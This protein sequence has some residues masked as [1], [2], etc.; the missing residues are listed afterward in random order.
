MI[1]LDMGPG[2][3]QQTSLC[4]SDVCLLNQ[5]GDLIAYRLVG[6]TEKCC[7]LLKHG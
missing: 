6:L 3:E 2:K 7:L 4:A 1:R 5:P